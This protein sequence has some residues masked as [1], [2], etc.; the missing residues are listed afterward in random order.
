MVTASQNEEK[1]DRGIKGG[2]PSLVMINIQHTPPQWLPSLHVGETESPT[3][4]LRMRFY[5]RD[6]VTINLLLMLRM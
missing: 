4:P 6:W 5:E 1:G 2:N 3:A